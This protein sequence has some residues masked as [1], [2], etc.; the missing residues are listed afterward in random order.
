LYVPKLNDYQI[1]LSSYV[2]LNWT[3]VKE[4]LDYLIAN[5]HEDEFRKYSM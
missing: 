4:A 5:S 1:L 2:S 3:I